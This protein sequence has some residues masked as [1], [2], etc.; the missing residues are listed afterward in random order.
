MKSKLLLTGSSKS[1][2][3]NKLWDQLTLATTLL[4]YQ[5]CPQYWYQNFIPI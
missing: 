5:Y 4:E 2:R 3:I 1:V